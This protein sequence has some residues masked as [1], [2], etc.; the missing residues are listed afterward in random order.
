MELT[1]STRSTIE[2]LAVFG[3]IEK[4]DFALFKKL[5]K[6]KHGVGKR[7]LRWAVI[8]CK[9]QFITFLLEEKVNWKW[10]PTE[11]PVDEDRCSCIN[12]SSDG[13]SAWDLAERL[14]YDSWEE[15]VKEIVEIFHKLKPFPNIDRMRVYHGWKTNTTEIIEQINPP[16]PSKN[17]IMRFV[18]LIQENWNGAEEK[19][20]RSF[21]EKY[22]NQLKNFLIQALRTRCARAVG[23]LIFLGAP[24]PGDA[25]S[26]IFEQKTPVFFPFETDPTTTVQ[27]LINFNVIPSPKVLTRFFSSLNLKVLRCLKKKY[28]GEWPTEV[29]ISD[30]PEKY[31]LLALEIFTNQ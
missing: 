16:S 4:G 22:G 30:D 26:E 19:E 12:C 3:A 8:K 25:F 15:E 28:K 11:L 31:G 24:I 18:E 23:N 13:M 1:S 7:A 21:A 10:C 5:W 27:I 2:E 29:Q 20:V 6:T 17:E 14:A 9:V